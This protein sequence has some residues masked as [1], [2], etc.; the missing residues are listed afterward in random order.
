MGGEACI[1]PGVVTDAGNPVMDAFGLPLGDPLLLED[2]LDA[3]PG[4]VGNGIFAHRS[5][6]V[7]IV[8]R[9]SGGI[10]RIVPGAEGT[11]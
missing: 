10:G 4:V 11:R 6:D 7:I 1:R 5:A 2:R 3:I 8:G 9:A